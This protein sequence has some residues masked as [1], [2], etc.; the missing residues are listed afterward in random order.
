MASITSLVVSMP[1][2]A[3][4]PKPDTRVMSFEVNVN[5]GVAHTPM[6]MAGYFS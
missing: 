1:K 3:S 4:A 2:R 5:M 6:R